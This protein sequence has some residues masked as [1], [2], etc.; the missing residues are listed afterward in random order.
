MF[1]WL[2]SPADSEEPPARAEPDAAAPLAATAASGW[3][4]RWLLTAAGDDFPEPDGGG[5]AATL[6]S[7]GGGGG[8]RAALENDDGRSPYED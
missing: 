8:G 2:S 7:C 5:G 1:P 4:L 3:S 6:A